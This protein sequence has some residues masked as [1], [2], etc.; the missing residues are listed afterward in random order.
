M[1]KDKQERILSYKP[2]IVIATPG[3]LWEFI[4]EIQNRFLVT[5]LPLIDFLVIDEADRMIEKGHFKEL[6]SILGYIYKRRAEKKSGKEP[7]QSGLINELKSKKNELS[8]E[9]NIGQLKVLESK[10]GVDMSKV[11]DLD[12]DEDMLDIIEEEGNLQGYSS[13][14]DDDEE[15]EAEIEENVA[16][17]V[18]D[19]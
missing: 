17:V 9:D 8:N 13:A 1:S 19:S 3:R 4:S 16:P 10:A 18:K 14:E 11:V 12:N 15:G 5:Q 7:K 2:Q 6:H